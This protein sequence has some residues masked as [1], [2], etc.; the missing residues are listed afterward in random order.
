[1]S[2]LPEQLQKQVDAAETF[3]KDA[4][5]S[6][7]PELVDTSANESTAQESERVVEPSG[8]TKAIISPA[9]DENSETY[10]QRW[11]S[12]QGIIASLNQKLSFAD[13]RVSQLESLISNMQSAPAEPTSESKKHLTE[14]DSEEYGEDMVDF[15]KRAVAEGTQSL[16]SENAELK[17]QLA[18]LNGVVPTVQKLSQQHQVSREDTFWNALSNKVPDWESVNSDSRFHSWLLDVDPMTGITRDVYLKDAQ[19]D[20]D[21]T[22]VSN[23][24][25]SWK[26]QFSVPS[27]QESSRNTAKS[28]LEMQIAPGGRTDSNNQ[29][30]PEAKKHRQVL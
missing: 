14:K 4:E 24:F 19:R 6:E 29:V 10:A 3:Y 13:Q 28:E 21:V 5:S 8:D 16:Q 15:V 30:A 2:K 23:I 20:L 7:K 27:K 26:Q 9:E 18:M 25:S 12:Q 1:M 11:R 22:R 17:R